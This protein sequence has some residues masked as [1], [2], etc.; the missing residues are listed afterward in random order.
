[1]A[2]KIANIGQ[3]FRFLSRKVLCEFFRCCV[4]PCIRYICGKMDTIKVS[5]TQHVDIEY[6]VAGLGERIAARLIDMAIF[7][8]LYFLGIIFMAILADAGMGEIG[9]IVMLIIFGALYVFYDLISE[10]FFNGQSVGKRAMKIKVISLDG[11]QPSL[12]QYLLRWT[13]RIVDFLLTSGLGALISVAVTTKKQR[14]GDIVANTTL[15]KTTPRTGLSAV[16]FKPSAE[17]YEPHFQEVDLLNDRDIGLVHE[18][19]SNYSKSGNSLLIYQLANKMKNHLNIEIPEGMDELNFLHT[20]VK[21]YN[22][23]TARDTN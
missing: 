19:L 15:I 14:I 1:M 5:T 11:A 23:I 16:A 10:L 13:F 17:N 9:I 3:C 6:D 18:V 8:L 7:I 20:I 21:D 4:L 2:I 22:A 12:G